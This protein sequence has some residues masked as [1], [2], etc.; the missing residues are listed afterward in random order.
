MN[1][2]IEAIKSLIN[3]RRILEAKKLIQELEKDL[4]RLKELEK[5]SKEIKR[6]ARNTGRSYSIQTADLE[7]FFIKYEIHL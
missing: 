3:S 1:E 5:F 4:D 6:L 2:K 7:A